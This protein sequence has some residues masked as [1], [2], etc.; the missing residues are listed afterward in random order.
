MVIWVT[1][2]HKQRIWGD[3]PGSL[4]MKWVKP[5]KGRKR[6]AE[7]LQTSTD[8]AVAGLPLC[9]RWEALRRRV[10]LREAQHRSSLG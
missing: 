10:V 8:L 6:K 3:T 9:E 1:F 2:C 4:G 5:P 7:A